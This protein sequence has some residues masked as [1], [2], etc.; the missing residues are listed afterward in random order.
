MY[1]CDVYKVISWRL[2]LIKIYMPIYEAMYI[3]KNKS[4]VEIQVRKAD[5]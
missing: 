1:V 5:Y 3:K 4:N 2:E